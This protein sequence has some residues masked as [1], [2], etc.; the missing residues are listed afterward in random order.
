MDDF[1]VDDTA[2]CF[3]PEMLVDFVDKS[4]QQGKEG[5]EPT[6]FFIN[7]VCLLVDIS[8]FTKLS[9]DFCGMGKSGIDELQLATNGYMGKLVEIIY[10]FGGEI[11]KFAGDAI[12]CVFSASFITA[13][14]PKKK[15]GKL[16]RSVYD[17]KHLTLQHPDGHDAP[18]AG[19]YSPV[20]ALNIVTREIP[21]VPPDVVLRAMHCARE[22]REVQT[23]KLSVHVAMSCGEMCFGI[24]GGVENRWECLISGPCIHQLADCLDDAPSK[25][26]VISPECAAIIKSSV[27]RTSVGSLVALADEHPDAVHKSTMHTA[28]GVYEFELQVLP[29]G[30]QRIVDITCV[31]T[32]EGGSAAKKAVTG[33]SN[34]E[35]SQ[36]IR[37]FVP[38]PI[39]DGLEQ[40]TGLSYLAEIREVTTMFMKVRFCRCRPNRACRG[41]YRCTHES[42][43]V[44]LYT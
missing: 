12:I 2:N 18:R 5:I 19:N 44:S 9:G 15:G 8:G 26:A 4:L 30:N 40:G 6:S 41:W 11:I 34:P 16:R 14:E 39:A 24:L 3:V 29:S 38:V 27:M 10:T 25:T 23:A 42:W 1:G 13:V 7:G 35:L 21:N 37:Q 20:P 22:L 31:E 36:L 33:R 28:A 43:L 17:F 32:V